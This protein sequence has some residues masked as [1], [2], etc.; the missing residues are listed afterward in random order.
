MI[1]KLRYLPLA[2]EDLIEIVVYTQN[3]LKNPIAAENILSK[4]EN[5][6]FK[7]LEN[8]EAYA[9]WQSSKKRELDYRIINV[10][11]YTIWYVVIGN[12]EVRRIL[13]SR[14][15]EGKFL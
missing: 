11:N 5:T 7:R 12:V 4:I 10:G 2:K 9:V 15:D 14:M 13:Y 1:Y 8:P 3:I 6:I